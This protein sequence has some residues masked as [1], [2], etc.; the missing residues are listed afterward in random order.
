[1]ERPGTYQQLL[2]PL[3]HIRGPLGRP[4]AGIHI[5]FSLVEELPIQC[6]DRKCHFLHRAQIYECEAAKEGDGSSKPSSNSRRRVPSRGMVS[7]PLCGDRREAGPLLT[8][9][10][11][12]TDTQ[13][14][15]GQR[16]S[17]SWG[18]WGPG[19]VR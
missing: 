3:G 2:G 13:V 4:V 7:S 15:A 14:W 17:W 10:E 16:G 6:L 9:K 12:T 19:D 1:M 5:Q 18:S 8:H 11:A